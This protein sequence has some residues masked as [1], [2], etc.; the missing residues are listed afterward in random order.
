MNALPVVHEMPPSGGAH[1]SCCLALP[2]E[3]PLRDVFTRDP[4]R[5]TCTIRQIAELAVD[6]DRG[7]SPFGWSTPD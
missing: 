6:S 3:L 1:T 4:R 7:E 2:G 5:V